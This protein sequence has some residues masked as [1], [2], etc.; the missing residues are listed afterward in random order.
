MPK[1]TGVLEWPELRDAV[2]QAE[3]M[4]TGI[5]G[6]SIGLNAMVAALNRTGIIRRLQ[7]SS[8]RDGGNASLFHLALL[9]DETLPHDVVEF[10]TSRGE[11]VGSMFIVGAPRAEVVRLEVERRT[12]SDG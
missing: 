3:R 6:T 8:D 1:V 7:I 5:H 12:R 4:V 9:I 2:E 11:V 10:R